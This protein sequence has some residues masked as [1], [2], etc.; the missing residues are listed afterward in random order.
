MG[1]KR[2]LIM[3]LFS[4]L[5]AFYL[6]D[7]Y[8]P[9][10]IC[11]CYTYTQYFSEFISSGR[12]ASFEDCIPSSCNQPVEPYCPGLECSLQ[13]EITPDTHTHWVQ[14]IGGGLFTM[15]VIFNYTSEKANDAPGTEDSPGCYDAADNDGNGYYDFC[16]K[17]CNLVADT[18]KGLSEEICDGI[19]NN[20]NG[21]IDEVCACL[22]TEEGKTR[23]CGITDVGECT[24]GTEVCAN[25][26]YQDCNA[27][28]P[29][30]EICDGKDNDCN[31]QVDEGCDDDNDNYCDKN[32]PFPGF[33]SSSTCSFGDN[34]CNDTNA[35]IHPGA[36]ETCN[37]IDDNCNG[38]TD[39]LIG[40]TTCGQGICLHTINNCVGGQIQTCN[41]MQGNTIE[42]CDGLNNDC[43]GQTDEGCDNDNDGYVNPAMDCAG[44]PR[45]KSGT[46]CYGGCTEKDCNDANATI[47][48]GATE[49]C[50]RID[51]NCDGIMDNVGGG[52]TIVT[53]HCQCFN[54]TGP[55][56]NS[57]GNQIEISNKID[58]NCN[59]EI[60]EGKEVTKIISKFNIETPLMNQI[61]VDLTSNIRVR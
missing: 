44:I 28:M 45:C 25:Y 4:F 47:H 18:H 42:I 60:D 21:E 32:V 11:T 33:P 15:P 12:V 37:Q 7:A 30:T 19:D 6:T 31:G 14:S 20:C 16:D 17:A 54:G 24:Y 39:E 23:P 52:N 41:P 55:L 9:A 22:I 61:W 1:K 38:Q 53:T 46:V 27:L 36:I 57:I 40:T 43:D 59:G 50:N 48:P 29:Q 5:T 58:D 34:D 10:G 26:K 13:A 3:F 51:D 56:T 49:I 8:P 2:F 35:A